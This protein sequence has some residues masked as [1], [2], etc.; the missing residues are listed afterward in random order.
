MRCTYQLST[1]Y[2]MGQKC[3]PL[4]NWGNGYSNVSC[5]V[6]HLKFDIFFQPFKWCEWPQP[7]FRS[8]RDESETDVKHS[9]FALAK[10]NEQ[11]GRDSSPHFLFIF[12]SHQW[13]SY[14]SLHLWRDATF[15]VKSEHFRN[16]FFIFA[17][18]W[19]EA[20]KCDTLVPYHGE[21]F[22]KM[23]ERN[24]N[25]VGWVRSHNKMTDINI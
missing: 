12:S 15:H 8:I 6:L 16:F 25:S 1:I 23:G 9:T 20:G 13:S 2:T 24:Q 11:G 10:P 7:W 3:P 21:L 5:W 18:N 14:L 19:F 17:P 4:C 22:R